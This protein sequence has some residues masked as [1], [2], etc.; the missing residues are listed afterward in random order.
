MKE[1]IYFGETV[2][3]YDIPVLNEREARA[4]AGILFLFGM[5]GFLNAY[6]LHDFIYTQIFVTYF[7][8]DF[9]IRI[10]INPKYAPS[11]ILGRFFVSNQRPEYVGAKQKRFAWSIGFALSIPMFIMIVILEY[12]T[13]VKIVICII[14]L[15]LL[16]FEAAFSICIGCKLYALVYGEK[17]E[18]CPG[19]ICDI[20]QKEEIQKISKFQ[21]TVLGI[22]LIIVS[23]VAITKIVQSDNSKSNGTMKC[24]VGK[25]GGN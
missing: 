17:A 3:G 1:H 6:L 21:A 18:H 12:M 24:G 2:K 13:P 4:A 20:K 25:C 9:T 8:I 16:F 5:I 11:L 7:M 15:M 22:T 10:F 23:S 19:G 14:C